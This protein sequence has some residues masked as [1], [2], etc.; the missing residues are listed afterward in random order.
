MEKEINF[1]KELEEVFSG[2][3]YKKL[4]LRDDP[5]TIE[6]KEK[7]KVFVD[8][9][10]PFNK[11][12]RGIKNM[13]SGFQPHIAVLGSH[14]IGKTHFIEF[15]FEFLQEHKSKIGIEEFYYIKGR[16]GFREVFLNEGVEK[17]EPYKK[18]KKSDKK[19][20]I[21]FDDIDITFKKYPQEI[22]SFF[23]TFNNCI[24]GTWDSHAWGILKNYNDFK[25]P[26]TEAVYIDRLEENYCRDLLLTRL[27]GVC[28][29]EKCF[30]AFPEFVINKLSVISDGNPYKLITYSK[31][32]L[33]FILENN[34][35]EIKEDEFG[36]FCNKLN[37]QFIDDI[38]KELSE[39]TDKQKRMV[40]FIIESIEISSKELALKYGLSRVG[41]MMNLKILKDKKILDSKT[42]DRTDFYYVPTELVFE[43]S[44]YLDKLNQEGRD[45]ERT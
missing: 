18:F 36:K 7:V 19:I 41:A 14:G 44:D 25:I 39:L 31:R 30:K 21:F 22:A 11:L 33:D 24:I 26:K 16:K 2:N 38:K 6:P 27:K 15:A 4:G 29:D 35:T 20:L 12:I 5:F 37:I 42:K 3:I 43:V 40:S 28:E 34:F 1:E 23:E 9:H 8:R 17:S 10:E 32:Y 45:S 13:V